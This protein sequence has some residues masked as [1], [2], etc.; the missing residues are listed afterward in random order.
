MTSSCF[1]NVRN[2]VVLMCWKFRRMLSS[3]CQVMLLPS[4]LLLVAEGV[5]APS[6]M[7]LSVSV[8]KESQ[9]FGFAGA[10]GGAAVGVGGNAFF[11][12]FGIPSIQCCGNVCFAVLIRN[13]VVH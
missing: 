3:K 13:L 8:A 9:F 12:E 1:C 2:K 6:G 5:E 10:D 11:C 7:R 4:G